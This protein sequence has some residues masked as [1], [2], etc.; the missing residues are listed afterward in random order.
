MVA[1]L[2]MSVTVP[3]RQLEVGL[4]TAK[5]GRNAVEGKL[6][7]AVQTLAARPTTD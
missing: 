2:A 4:F 5:V 7:E 1:P 3:P 6:T